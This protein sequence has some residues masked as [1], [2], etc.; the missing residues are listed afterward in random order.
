MALGEFTKQFAKQALSEQVTDLLDPARP[1][2]PQAAESVAVSILNQIQ[3]MQRA[4]K[5]DQELTVLF[6][7]GQEMI[8]IVEVYLP[9]TQLIVLTGLDANRNLTRVI[10]PPDATQLVCKITKVQP[11]IAPARINL[12]HATGAA[13]R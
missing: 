10:T 7:T 8:R 3:A 5:E 11:G 13:P 6:H 1:P 12:I 2:K 4:C 9:S